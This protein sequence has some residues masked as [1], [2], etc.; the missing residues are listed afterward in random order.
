MGFSDYFTIILAFAVV[1]AILLLTTKYLAYKTKT[2]QKGNYMHIVETLSLGV[3]NRLHLIKVDKEFFIISSSNKNI[4]F[5][6]RVNIEDYQEEEIKNP[7]TEVVDFKSLLKKYLAGV[8]ITKP[9]ENETAA[10]V[11]NKAET[12]QSGMEKQARVKQNLEILKI[13]TKSMNGQRSE[14][15]QEK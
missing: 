4:E 9:A 15:E 10:V 12:E 1:I 2:L 13:F 6:A 3:N 14:N 5:L 8:N 7:I 11:K